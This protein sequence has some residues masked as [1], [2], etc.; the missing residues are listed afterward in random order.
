[1]AEILRRLLNLCVVLRYAK[2]N[3][4]YTCTNIVQEAL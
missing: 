3:M 1:M 4:L 2:A